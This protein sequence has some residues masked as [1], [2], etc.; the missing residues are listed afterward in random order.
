MKTYKHLWDKFISKENFELAYKNSIKRKSKQKQ[1]QEFQKDLNNNLEAVRQLVISGNFHTSKYRS[2]T[3]YEPKERIIY[4]LPYNPD[5]IVQH[6]VMNILKPILL[7]L[8][9]ENNYGSIENRGPHKASKKCAEFTRKYKY[10]LKCDIKKFYPSI[11]QNILSNM[12]H[13]IIKDIKFMIIIDDIIFSFPG[14]KNCPI[15]NYCSQWFGNF[16]LSILDNF[17]LHKL[18]CKAYLRYCDD[19]ILYANDKLYLHKCKYLIKI[20]LYNNLL[21]IF[22]KSQIGQTKYGV[23]FCGYRCFKK[24]VLLR[25]STAKRIQKRFISI[26]YLIKTNNFN[27]LRI[28]G[29][30]ASA[31][32]QLKH[33][34]SYNFRKSLDIY[35][36]KL[37][38][39]N[40]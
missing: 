36:L 8:F 28:Q 11:D 15:G 7:N 30:I 19:F 20:F 27:K 32:G 9:I 37:M 14:N 3:I 1:I 26:K 17:I 31:E 4:K 10:Y 12:F 6:A 23:D 33:C 38:I 29:Q 35:T 18:K 25:K 34:C 13:R 2:Q 22:S 5:R 16:Y 24:Y 39:N 40:V 21:L